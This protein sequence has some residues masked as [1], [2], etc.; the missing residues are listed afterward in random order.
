MSSS[1][2]VPRHSY[3]E[4][5]KR[6]DNFLRTYNP[7]GTIPVPI[8]EIVEFEFGINI[9]PIPGLHQ[10]FEIDGFISSDL[11]VI[12]VDQFVYESRPGRYRFTLAHELGHAVL[13]RRV[14]EKASISSIKEWK[15]FVAEIDLQDYEWL[16]WQAYAFAG[17]ILVP[18]VPLKK[19]FAKAVDQAEEAGL[20]I[21]KAGDV[22]K[23]YI[24]SWLAK[25]F[26][27]SS[28]VIEKRLDKDK[29]WPGRS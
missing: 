17:L 5:R 27:V 16:E 24:S 20:S 23:L 29:L 22:A 19:K 26:D 25:E 2:Q 10:G 11:T 15:Q 18:Q 7:K 1:L 4:L 6:T 14:Y 9:V 3:E 8:E 21:R 13:H 28:Q 12:S